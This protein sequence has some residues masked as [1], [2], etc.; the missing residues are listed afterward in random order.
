MVVRRLIAAIQIPAGE[1]GARA[2]LPWVA[3]AAVTGMGCWLR[4]RT[5][6]PAFLT[7]DGLHPSLRAIDILRREILPWRGEAVGFHF[8]MLQAWTMVPLTAVAGSLR[9]VWLINAVIHGLGAVAICM[10][11]RR[12][13]SW[14]VGLV[15][16]YV[17]GTW[18]ILVYHPQGGAWTYHAPVFV[19][20]GLWAATVALKRPSRWATWGL[21]AAL[22]AAIHMHPFALSVGV[23]GLLLG[24]RLMRVQGLRR[25][26][27]A[28]VVAAIVLSPMVIDNIQ[29]I[30]FNYPAATQVDLVEGDFRIDWALL[31]QTL[32]SLETG[33]PRGYF[34]LLYAGLVAGMVATH[35]RW[36]A[37]RK[38]DDGGLLVYWAVLSYVL[39]LA[40]AAVLHYVR[41][42]HA[43]PIAPLHALALVWACAFLLES[44]AVR[45]PRWARTA[46]SAVT[47]LL[48]FL[49]L[50]AMLVAAAGSTRP[51][52]GVIESPP[53][54]T[55][56]AHLSVLDRIGETIHRDAGDR[57]FVLYQLVDREAFHDAQLTAL[58]GDLFLRGAD[59][60]HRA[61]AMRRAES[62]QLTYV[63]VSVTS[64]MLRAWEGVPEP[65][66][67]EPAGAGRTIAVY[68]FGDM[69]DALSWL[70]AGCEHLLVWPDVEMQDPTFTFV[71][72]EIMFTPAGDD[73][74]SFYRRACEVRAE[75]RERRS[76]GLV[77][78]EPLD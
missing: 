68:R 13:H 35:P 26:I 48:G 42:S 32:V 63:V 10:A 78:E 66:F 16:A 47:A 11:G 23:A 17:Y 38:A 36:W 2:W 54:E 69:P 41:P 71:T 30:F 56:L 43:G 7:Q 1:K 57:L 12:L 67:A 27:E 76:R 74:R 58:H 50:G 20:L 9:Q 31:L 64:A 3:L 55:S 25:V 34:V 15:A 72:S 29:T 61:S 60:I 73:L 6:E 44:I 18:P 5:V 53:E 49:L 4:L 59:G 8:G 62:P 65:L 52:E 70:D 37:L 45:V 33:W 24:P 21:V 46:G 19:A 77:P 75:D 39:L 14:G 22:A 51:T 40:L 28:L